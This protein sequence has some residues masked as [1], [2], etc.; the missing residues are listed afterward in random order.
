MNV[1][2]KMMN[3]V[4]RMMNIPLKLAPVLG[5][6]GGGAT[7][8]AISLELQLAVE[9]ETPSTPLARSSPRPGHRCVCIRFIILNTHF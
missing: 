5:S 7:A 4:L 9:G 6:G 2:F 3:F 1:P 8:A